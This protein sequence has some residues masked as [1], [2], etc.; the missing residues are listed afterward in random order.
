MAWDFITKLPESKEPIS[1]AQHDSI[2][3][4]TDKLTKF[5][6]FLPYRKSSIIKELVYIFLRRIVANYGFLKKII[7]DRDKLFILK[8]WQVLIA[9]IGIKI[10]LSIIF[11]PQTDRQTE[12]INQNIE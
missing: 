7:L 3:V 1:N 5:G 2:L 6:Y 8:F 10:K 9:K 11:H 4:I 12:K